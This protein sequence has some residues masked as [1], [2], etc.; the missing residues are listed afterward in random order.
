MHAD[1]VPPTAVDRNSVTD[2]AENNSIEPP[3]TRASAKLIAHYLIL[4]L[5]LINE[6]HRGPQELG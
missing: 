3:P 2:R 6:F 1:R 5:K 4:G